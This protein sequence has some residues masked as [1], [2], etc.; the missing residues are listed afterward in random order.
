M[1]SIVFSGHKQKIAEFAADH[2]DFA[3]QDGGLLVQA[4]GEMVFQ[5][6]A[7][8]E[9]ML[10]AQTPVHVDIIR[11]GQE[12]ISQPFAVTVFAFEAGQIAVLLS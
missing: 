11:D 4:E 6:T 9:N 3:R 1:Q 8:V 12:V 7:S 5:D 2:I 10:N